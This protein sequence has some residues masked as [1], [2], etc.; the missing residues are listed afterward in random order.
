MSSFETS[1]QH[2][3]F[4]P[5]FGNLSTLKGASEPASE[6][7]KRSLLTPEMRKVFLKDTSKIIERCLTLAS[8]MALLNPTVLFATFLTS[9]YQRNKTLKKKKYNLFGLDSK[10]IENQIFSVIKK[11]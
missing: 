8:K 6:L 7:S 10:D 5:A 3:I 1:N 4:L 9:W 2:I 11:A